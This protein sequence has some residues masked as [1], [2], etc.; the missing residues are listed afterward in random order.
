M[1]KWLKLGLALAVWGLAQEGIAQSTQETNKNIQEVFAQTQ[2][3]KNTD[4]SNTYI[5]SAAD[6]KEQETTSIVDV[7][8]VAKD[9]KKYTDQLV[10]IYGK[11]GLNTKVNQIMEE[12]PDFWKRTLQQQKNIVQQNFSDIINDTDGM[13]WFIAGLVFTLWMMWL[14]RSTRVKTK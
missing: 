14:N 6:F 8:Q 7:T 12:H 1:K 3:E 5:T 10:K 13:V 2:D 9:M 11:K 4:K